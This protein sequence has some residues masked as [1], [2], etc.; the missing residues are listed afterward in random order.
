MEITGWP[1][2]TILRGM[3][4]MQDDELLGSAVGQPV[5]FQKEEVT[6]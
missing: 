6:G 5:R 2:M 3:P 4:I 1:V